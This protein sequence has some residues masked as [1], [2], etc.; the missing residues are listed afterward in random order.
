M[1]EIAYHQMQD[2][3]FRLGINLCFQSF[4]ISLLKKLSNMQQQQIVLALVMLWV[5]VLP[6]YSTS[7]MN[8]PLQIGFFLSEPS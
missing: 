3:I 5:R 7:K 6:P 1:T 8:L 4:S 2:W